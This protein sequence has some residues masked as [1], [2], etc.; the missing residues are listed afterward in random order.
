MAIKTQYG[1]EV[2]PVEAITDTETGE[3]V[4]CFATRRIDGQKRFYLLHQL[5]A[6]E[7][8]AEILGVLGA[9]P[10]RSD[11]ELLAHDTY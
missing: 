6:T 5:R 1:N 11:A 9:L 7:G 2:R 4:A 10:V 8:I 3:F